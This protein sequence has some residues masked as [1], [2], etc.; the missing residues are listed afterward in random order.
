MLGGI[1]SDLAYFPTFLIRISPYI[2]YFSFV[3][4][5]ILIPLHLLTV[6]SWIAQADL[7]VFSFLLIILCI[8]YPF[9]PYSFPPFWLRY[10]VGMFGTDHFR[11]CIPL[12]WL[13]FII[14]D[15]SSATLHLRC[16][17]DSFLIVYL[18]C[19]LLLV[20]SKIIP[21]E[22]LFPLHYPI[23]SFVYFSLF[24]YHLSILVCKL[25]FFIIAVL[26]PVIAA[27]VSLYSKSGGC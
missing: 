18:A 3:Q 5:C 8:Y 23:L 13:T 19:T 16:F 17:R 26:I 15:V 25:R 4:F 2:S 12:Y 7:G 27:F 10:R 14:S 6:L 11:V 21:L 24:L 1:L 20:A 22:H 9:S